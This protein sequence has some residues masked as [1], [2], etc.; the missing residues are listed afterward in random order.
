MNPDRLFFQI[1]PTIFHAMGAAVC[2][3]KIIKFRFQFFIIRCIYKFL[4]LRNYI[5]KTIFGNTEAFKSLICYVIKIRPK[6]N[7]IWVII[8]SRTKKID[9]TAKLIHRHALK[10][11]LLQDHLIC[12]LLCR[13]L[14][15]TGEQIVQ[16]C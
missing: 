13:L 11:F 15:H 12:D 16:T 10:L 7:H 8:C 6:V 1:Q 14:T 9:H 2:F 5:M 3:Q 4:M